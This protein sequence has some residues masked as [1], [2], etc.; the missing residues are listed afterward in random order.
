M[1]VKGFC[2]PIIL[3][4]GSGSTSDLRFENGVGD[5]LFIFKNLAIGD[6]FASI[7]PVLNEKRLCLLAAIHYLT[8]CRSNGMI[9]SLTVNTSRTR[10]IR[11]TALF[12]SSRIAGWIYPIQAVE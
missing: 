6:L 9:V 4:S 3:I 7:N 8:V 2:T 11:M 12:E 1:G 10:V 5:F